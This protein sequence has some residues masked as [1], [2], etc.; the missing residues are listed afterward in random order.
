MWIPV[1]T[2]VLKQMASG[3]AKGRFPISYIKK[4]A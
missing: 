2:A 1:D 4:L 3:N